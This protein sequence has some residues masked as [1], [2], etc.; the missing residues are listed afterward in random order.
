MHEIPRNLT[1]RLSGRWRP[2]PLRF[3]L[4][5]LACALHARAQPSVRFE[6][7]GGEAI[8]N[9]VCQ[10]CHMPGAIGAKGAGS[11]PALAGDPALSGRAYPVY[12]I[13]NGRKAMPAFGALLDDNQIADVVNYI[14]SHFGNDYSDEV[15]VDEVKAVRPR[16]SASADANGAPAPKQAQAEGYASG[17]RDG[18]RTR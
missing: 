18:E 8:F 2:R 6:E 5:Y 17:T 11:Y 3:A 10:A 16:D 14:R 9:G 13:V 1:A 7:H 4:I 12:V 15:T